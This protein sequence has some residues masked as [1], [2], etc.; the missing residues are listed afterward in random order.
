MCDAH[1]HAALGDGE[2][3]PYAA[4]KQYPTSNGHRVNRHDTGRWGDDGDDP[5][6]PPYW[7][8]PIGTDD[9]DVAA[10]WEDTLDSDNWIIRHPRR[11]K[12]N[13]RRWCKGVPGREHNT[14]L[15]LEPAYGRG[16]QERTT[17][18]RG[19]PGTHWSCQHKIVCT[20]CGK[21]LRFLLGK[22]ECPTWWENQGLIMPGTEVCDCG[23]LI[24]PCPRCG[25]GS[26]PAC[27]ALHDTCTFTPVTDR[28]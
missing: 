23:L 28:V 18:V 10:R 21:I 8:E 27:D 9:M 15:R 3:M 11:R 5:A 6:W 16:C 19:Q 14:E 2:R 7:F 17:Y 12:K 4:V 20:V 22:T 1:K 26:C 24:L 13:T 25:E